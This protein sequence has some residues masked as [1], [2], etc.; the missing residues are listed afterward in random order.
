MEAIVEPLMIPIQMV[1]RDEFA[2]GMSNRMLKQDHQIIC[3]RQLSFPRPS[4]GFSRDSRTHCGEKLYQ[5]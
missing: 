2:N 3:S 4:S 5:L 1:M